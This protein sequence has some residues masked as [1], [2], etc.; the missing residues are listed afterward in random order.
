ML[1]HSR[2]ELALDLG[3]GLVF[4]LRIY[5]S[6]GHEFKFMVEF[7]VVYLTLDSFI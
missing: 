4:D 6:F 1:T 3:L 7:V 2:L 5:L